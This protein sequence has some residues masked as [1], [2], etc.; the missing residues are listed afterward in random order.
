AEA[1]ILLFRLSNPVK[2]KETPVTW[3]YSQGDG[4]PSAWPGIEEANIGDDT[5]QLCKNG[6]IQLT[7][8]D[9]WS[10]Q[11][12]QDWDGNLPDQP[13]FW[14]GIKIGQA[15]S[16]LTLG[17]EH[18][19]FNSVS[20]TNAL[21]IAEPERIG[22]SNGEPFQFFELA[23]QPLFKQSATRTPYAH[24]LIESREPQGNGAFG[25]WQTWTY[26]DDL[27]KGAGN[28]FRLD[29]VTGTITFGNYDPTT[30]ADGHGS[31]PVQGSEIRA[32]S[33]RYVAGGLKGNVPPNKLTV[34]RTVAADLTGLVSITNPGLATGGSNEETIEET[35]RRGPEALRNRNRAITVEDYEYLAREATTDVKKV[36]CLPPRF[37]SQYDKR[38][39]DKAINDPWTFGGLNRDK[40]N[41][42]VIIIPEAPLSNTMPIPSVEL[43]QEVSD[44]LEARRAITTQLHVT[45]PRYLPINAAVNVRIWEQARDLGLVVSEKQVEL[46]IEAKIKAFLHPLWGGPT[47][48]GWEIGQDILLSNLFEFIQPDPKVGFISSLTI[49]AGTPAYQ[50]PDRPSFESGTVSDV[51]VQLADYEMLCSGEHTVEADFISG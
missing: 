29:P 8:P 30:S 11:N 49:T 19:L 10:S 2:D 31:I 37:F 39:S 5:E 28:Y 4:L 25:S 38:P 7:L 46:D 24:L 44:F 51:W 40:G 27:P 35:K 1:I 21:T 22:I 14:L 41:V 20:A 13:L 33:Y 23:Q 16:N 36:R 3:H 47:Q 6:R 26:L 17:F 45:T 48:T 42:N 43:L 12:S 34:I 32:K 9:D 18:I 15:T 50:P